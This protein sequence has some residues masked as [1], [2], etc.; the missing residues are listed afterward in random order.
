VFETGQHHG[1]PYFTME[2]VAGG[3]LSARLDGAPLPPAQVAPLLEPLARAV[4]YAH[5]MGIVHRDLKPA[6]VLLSPLS[7]ER[8]E[9]ARSRTERGAGGEGDFTPK[10]TDFGLAKRVEGASF[11]QAGVIL[12]T[13]SYMA[14]EQAR[15]RAAE[16]GPHADVWALGAILYECLTG[17][18]PF[19]GPTPTDTMLQVI[20]KEP[21]PPRR[22][23]PGVPRD[24]ETICL[25]CLEKQPSQRYASAEALADDLRRFQAGKPIH[26]RPLGLPER[27]WR[28]C[29]RNP[30]VAGLAALTAF[31]FLVS[32]V[33]VAALWRQAVA[34]LAA[35]EAQRRRADDER[36][37]AEEEKQIAE[38]VGRFL[39]IDLLRQAD[40]FE[41]AEAVRL[42]G[43]RFE[44][45]E[46]P[47]VRELLDRAAAGLAGDRIEA[48]FPK[49]P[50]S[51][52]EILR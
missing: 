37:R 20:H 35:A 23:Q 38:A 18:P 4:H 7:P 3:S 12:G 21:V 6:N 22:L 24:L 5:Q 44:A 26:A 16:V 51:Q 13:P 1:Q 50:R 32:F 28:W 29:R 46:N 11:T 25:K 34:N 30:M 14:P 36:D 45:Q 42:A 33:L 31:V 10:V 19:Q 40:P 47:T 2:L 17:R 52:A 9:K 41:Q 27:G 48:K 15:G 8:T 39:Q 49:Q 43:G